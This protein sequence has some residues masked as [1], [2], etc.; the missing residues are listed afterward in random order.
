MKR[1]QRTAARRA[2]SRRYDRKRYAA[3][4]RMFD[5]LISRLGAICELCE[6]DGKNAPLEVDHVDGRGWEKPARE[7]RYDQRVKRYYEEFMRGV[8]L[9]VL[10]KP[11][12]SGYRPPK[13]TDFPPAPF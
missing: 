6:E 12:N 1:R 13:A 7:Y 2:A 5:D 10:C 3:A 4:K 9:R 8:K 11:C